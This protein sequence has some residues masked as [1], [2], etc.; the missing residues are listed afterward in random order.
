MTINIFEII[1][2][3]RNYFLPTST[4]VAMVKNTVTLP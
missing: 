2:Y 4:H 1:F 3:Q